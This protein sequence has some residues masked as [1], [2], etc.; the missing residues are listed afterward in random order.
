MYLLHRKWSPSKYLHPHHKWLSRK[1]KHNTQSQPTNRRRKSIRR[2]RNNKMWTM[3]QQKEESTSPFKSV[4][5]IKCDYDQ[6]RPDLPCTYCA[7]HGLAATCIKVQSQG[8]T[9]NQP[10]NVQTTSSTTKVSEYATYYE[11][12]YPTATPQQ[13]LGYLNQAFQSS[14]QQSPSLTSNNGGY[15]YGTTWIVYPFNSGIWC[16][17]ITGNVY[18]LLPLVSSDHSLSGVYQSNCRSL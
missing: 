2:S 12:I 9:A 3:P 14:P 16:S 15:F 6:S 11:G 13:I 17:A 4:D 7:N 18:I 1:N 5:L 8:A 10:A